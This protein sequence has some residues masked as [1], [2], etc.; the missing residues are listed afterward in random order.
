MAPAIAHKTHKPLTPI[1]SSKRSYVDLF[2]PGLTTR[3][4]GSFTKVQ[5]LM[6]FLP[7]EE[8]KTGKISR[9]TISIYH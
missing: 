8:T 1:N 7:Q 6:R 3:M 9:V 4:G 5:L 2:L